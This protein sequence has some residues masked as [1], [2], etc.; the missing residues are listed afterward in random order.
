MGEGDY[1]WAIFLSEV[2]SE[3]C[4]GLLV[5]LWWDSCVRLRYVRL[6][7]VTRSSMATRHYA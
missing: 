7:W 4:D 3:S 1:Y 2:G 6:D 5:E